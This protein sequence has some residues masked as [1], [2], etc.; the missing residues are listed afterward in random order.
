M[1]LDKKAV[2]NYVLLLCG[3]FVCGLI[4]TVVSRVPAAV[5][6][7][8][9]AV[10]VLFAIGFFVTRREKKEKFCNKCGQVY[11]VDDIEYEELRRYTKKNKIT[12][13]MTDRSVVESLYYKIR[14]DCTCSNCGAKK[15]F[16]KDICGG[17][18]YFDGS[19]E[20]IDP[21]ET[22]EEYF[23]QPNL[24]LNDKRLSLGSL[25]VGILAF[26]VAGI[27]GIVGI[28]GNLT[29]GKN[30][31]PLDDYYGVYYA[32]DETNYTE[33]KLTIDSNGVGLTWHYLTCDEYTNYYDKGDC[34][35]YNAEYSKENFPSIVNPV[36]D[37]SVLSL[38]N[39][40][41]LLTLSRIGFG[42]TY[43]TYFTFDTED[44]SSVTFTSEYI[45]LKTVTEDPENYYGVYSNANALVV[46]TENDCSLVINGENLGRFNYFYA[47]TGVLRYLGKTEYDKGLVIYNGSHQ[48]IVIN[49]DGAGD[50]YLYGE[51]K[52][53]KTA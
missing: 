1:K 34:N 18:A 6:F 45:S 50:L 41:F 53:N 15:T 20:C 10:I 11:G 17:N 32:F 26:L 22:I 52:L 35:L 13:Q 27:V 47:N 36:F 40:D 8:L 48:F 46:L 2:R 31:I 30:T 39:N 43:V 16:E 24:S 4:I 28:V 3:I 14:F 7:A 5:L 25:I 42:D 49:I 9:F 23:S 19:Q 12:S 29:S 51:Q 33:F 38:G 44:G 37:S 21:E